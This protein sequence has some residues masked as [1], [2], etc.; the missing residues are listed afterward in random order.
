MFA[1][2]LFK[3][4]AG[5]EGG[6]RRRWREIVA[7]LVRAGQ[8]APGDYVKALGEGPGP[9]RWVGAL[10]FFFGA[11]QLVAGAVMFFAYNWR[12][13]PDL[14]KIALPQ[15]AMAL[16][17]LV[18]AAAPGKSPI[19]AVAGVAATVMIG[20]SMGVVGQ[21]YQLGADPWTL[22][23]TWAAFATPLALVA[24]SDAQFALAFFISTA[25]YFLW[26]EIY[27]EP[28]FEA[29]RMATPALYSLAALAVLLIRDFAAASIAGPQPAWQR[30]LF[31]A[32]ALLPAVGAALG[33]T[34][35][36]RIFENGAVGTLALVSVAAAIYFAYR[37]VRP[38]RPVRAL[39]LF[40]VAIVVGGAGLRA[41]WRNDFD[42]AG[43]FAIG[44][45]MSA[46]YV[47]GVT[48][49]LAALLREPQRGEAS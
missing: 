41:V 43:E 36:D 29:I 38:D 5:P 25:A 28:R 46:L 44:F 10:V 6:G 34:T 26:A 33:E 21:V 15:A 12:D 27:V 7:E 39:S 4:F 3:R 11:A 16:A 20:V 13:L 24:R 1:E 45:L 35:A 47:V 42:G 30:W 18:F 2:G 32:A 37:F 31:A 40:A 23:A 48:A 14:A 17:F 22:F 49:A 8:V 19:S 9:S